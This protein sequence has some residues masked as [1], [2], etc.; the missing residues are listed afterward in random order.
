MHEIASEQMGRGWLGISLRSVRGYAPQ[1][2]K[3]DQAGTQR[4]KLEDRG[5]CAGS[6]A[7]DR[8]KTQ[9]LTLRLSF[10][11]VAGVVL[12]SSAVHL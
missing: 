3:E 6:S 11:C 10:E 4:D 7:E 9:C 8:G 1:T 5:Q 2:H 12:R